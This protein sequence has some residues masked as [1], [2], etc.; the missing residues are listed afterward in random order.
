VGSEYG[1]ET[2]A[3]MVGQ[4]GA[5]EV[6][7]SNAPSFPASCFLGVG[8]Y[9][10]LAYSGG[11][12]YS[13]FVTADNLHNRSE[14]QVAYPTACSQGGSFYIDK[15]SPMDGCTATRTPHFKVHPGARLYTSF[16]LWTDSYHTNGL[17]PEQF[18]FEW[19]IGSGSN[20]KI[21]GA[22]TI[23]DYIINQDTTLNLRVTKR[24]DGTCDTIPLDLNVEEGASSAN[25]A[26]ILACPKV[27]A[28]QSSRPPSPPPPPPPPPGSQVTLSIQPD[29]G[30]TY[31]WYF[32]NTTATNQYFASG[33]TVYDYPTITTSYAVEPDDTISFE[34]WSAGTVTVCGSPSVTLP[35]DRTIARGTPTFIDSTVTGDTPLQYQWYTVSG[36]TAT[37]VSPN[38]T[39]PYLNPTP[40]QTTTY[41]LTATNS[42]GSA[43]DD[44]VVIVTGDP[45]TTPVMVSVR[46]NKTT[47]NNEVTWQASS[48]SAGLSQYVIERSDGQTMTAQPQY[49][50]IYDQYN[51]IAGRTYLYRVKA[52]DIY[53]VSSGF[54]ARDLTTRLAF[55]DD[56]IKAPTDNGGTLII[57]A[58]V[59]ELRRAVD[60]VRAA[61]ALA[62]AWSDYTAPAGA[63]Y[64]TQ[65]IELRDRLNEARSILGFANVAFTDSVVTGQKIMGRTVTELR[66]GV[67]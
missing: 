38:G 30:E 55:S 61:A 57:G 52:V 50:T 27:R 47:G 40:Q 44:I 35:A 13:A 51:V 23:V 43:S 10:G 4:T 12:F 45:P 67:R 32:T 54:S 58:H 21:V 2:R 11:R 62:P 46:Y 19:S 9:Q 8:E 26:M 37:P 36:G 25:G 39:S 34:R 28:V 31:R 64:A 1:L 48:S 63:V 17:P 15:K 3:K 20:P 33:P 53:N 65:F 29:A 5:T 7:L 59:S 60:A 18:T 6:T 66:E 22:A 41:R 56:P 16:G 24:S 14:I 49:T 42:C